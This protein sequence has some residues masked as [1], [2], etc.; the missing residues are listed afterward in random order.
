MSFAA[1]FRDNCEDA[2]AKAIGAFAARDQAIAACE[3]QDL[4]RAHWEYVAPH[5]DW[6]IGAPGCEWADG[7]D[8]ALY[9]VTPE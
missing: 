9:D 7:C 5:L 2:D 4:S 1:R 8:G 3:R 6:T